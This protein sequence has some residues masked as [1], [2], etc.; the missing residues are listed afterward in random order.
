MIKAKP[1]LGK[2]L[3]N[4][5]KEMQIS[6]Q[7]LAFMLNIRVDELNTYLENKMEPSPQ[8]IYKLSEVL[9]VPVN[10]FL[11]CCSNITKGKVN[12]YYKETKANTVQPSDTRGKDIKN[13]TTYGNELEQFLCERLLD[14]T[15]EIKVFSNLK[16]YAPQ[17]HKITE[18]DVLVITK[19]ALYSIEVKRV[20]NRLIGSYSDRYWKTVSG[21]YQ[22]HIYNPIIQNLMH[23]RA[24]KSNLRKVC[25]TKINVI[26]LW[27][28]PDE[29]ICDV[30]EFQTVSD[31]IVKINSDG[32]KFKNSLNID[33]VERHINSIRCN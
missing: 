3:D 26:P 10:Y 15:N 16:I 14:S 13:L 12:K 7:D 5:M 2:R 32:L 23:T 33:D 27:C 22:K 9:K 21:R 6:E 1:N 30:S 17:L 20:R 18:I 31:I 25:S 11:N 29:V 24:L 4:R 28:K 19:W 8:I